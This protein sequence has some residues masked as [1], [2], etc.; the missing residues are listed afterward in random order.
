VCLGKQAN[1]HL[2]ASRLALRPRTLEQYIGASIKELEKIQKDCPDSFSY[3]LT[4]DCPPYRIYIADRESSS[5][6]GILVFA[7]AATETTMMPSFHVSNFM[8]S[9]FQSVY[10]DAIRWMGLQLSRK[11]FVIHGHNEAHHREL[12]ELL[13]GFGVEPVVLVDQVGGGAVTVMEKFEQRATPCSFAIA[14]FTP[15]DLVVKDGEE[16]AQPRLNVS[17]EVGW[18]CKHLGRHRVVLLVRA[19]LPPVSIY[20]SNLSGVLPHVFQKNVTELYKPLREE[21]VLAGLITA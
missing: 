6:R 7:G 3:H 17:F 5:P 1:T 8:E 2:W 12:V 10:T 4:Q 18:F 9:P 13:Q 11:V 15:D 19:D 14:L 20:N 16:S 21:L